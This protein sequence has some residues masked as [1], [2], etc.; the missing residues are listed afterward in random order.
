LV[1]I[2]IPTWVIGGIVMDLSFYMAGRFRGSRAAYGIAGAVYNVPGDILLYWAFST[3]L[4][5]AWPMLFFIYGF[6]MIHAILGGLA[7]IFVP[8]ILNRIKP[9]ITLKV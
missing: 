6:V 3:F 8:D 5:W 7:G 4:G 9:V 2:I 1:W